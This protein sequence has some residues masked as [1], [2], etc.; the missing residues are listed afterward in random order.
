MVHRGALTC[1]ST[2]ITFL[3]DLGNSDHFKD[4]LKEMNQWQQINYPIVVWTDEI[5]YPLLLNLF[6]DHPKVQINCVPLK[7]FN[8]NKYQQKLTELYPKYIVT[9]RNIQKDTE[10]YHLLMWTRYEMYQRSIE[11]N[12]FKTKTFICLDFGLTRFTSSLNEI[13]QWKISDQVKMLLIKPY[14][15]D[16]PEPFDYFHLTRHNVAGGLITGSGAKIKEIIQLFYQELDSL[17]AQ[18]VSTG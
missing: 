1:E 5:Y 10:Y 17:L 8:T 15:N 12:P 16:D 18:G 11:E 3:Y 13:E 14:T 2:L 4:R 7:Q 6:K 9:N